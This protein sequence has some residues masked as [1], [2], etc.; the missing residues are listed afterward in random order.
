M[1][2]GYFAKILP[3]LIILCFYWVVYFVF[4]FN[5]LYGQDGH[6]YFKYSK[7][8]SLYFSQGIHPEDYYWPIYYPL[9]GAV[10]SLFAMENLRA[11]QLISVISFCGIIFYIK[12]ILKLL[13]TDKK[14]VIDIYLSL[15]LCLAPYMLRQSVFVMSDMCAFFFMIATVYYIFKYQ[16]STN[17]KN[18]IKLSILGCL[19]VLTRYQ[20]G[21]LLFFPLLYFLVKIIKQKKYFHLLISLLFSL[22]LLLPHIWLKKETASSFMGNTYFNSW[23]ISNFFATSFQTTE[24]LM[25]YSYPNVLYVCSSTLPTLDC[26]IKSAH[27]CL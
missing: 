4:D 25:S 7:K 8:I 5:G 24:G 3:Y 18:C 10:A 6:S 13:T 21:I 17:L 11:L 19:A 27:L 20:M 15:C 22:L 9:L 12:N 26:W 14:E 1:K 2:D 16:E 23:S